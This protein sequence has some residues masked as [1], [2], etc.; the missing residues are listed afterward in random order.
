SATYTAT[1]FHACYR[2]SAICDVNNA[3]INAL[4]P[5]DGEGN[6]SDQGEDA[7]PGDIEMGAMVSTA[8]ETGGGTVAKKTE[9]SSAV[10]PSGPQPEFDQ[11]YN[12]TNYVQFKVL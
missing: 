6:G 11:K 10:V 3:Q 7:S 1:D 4:C 8:A 9:T 2:A 12:A 5:E